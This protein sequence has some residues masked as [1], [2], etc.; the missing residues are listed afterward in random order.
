MTSGEHTELELH[1][2][3][4]PLCRDAMVQQ[5]NRLLRH[6]N[7]H[8]FSEA[9]EKYTPKWKKGKSLHNGEH[10]LGRQLLAKGRVTIR[11]LPSD[12]LI[13]GGNWLSV[14]YTATRRVP[15]LPC[16]WHNSAVLFCCVHKRKLL[17]WNWN[18]AEKMCVILFHVL[19]RAWW[20]QIILGTYFRWCLYY[21]LFRML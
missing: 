7:T 9:P 2:W 11:S 17:R 19:V 21:V 1:T 14:C 15:L 16:R 18:G 20:I 6:G 5:R 3:I 13:T 8:S 10:M 12:V 4:S